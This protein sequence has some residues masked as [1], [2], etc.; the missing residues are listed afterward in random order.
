MSWRARSLLR[1]LR[2][3]PSVEPAREAP[4]PMFSTALPRLRG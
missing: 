4:H 3:S 1:A 2:R